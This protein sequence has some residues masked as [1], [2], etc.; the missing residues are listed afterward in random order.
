MEVYCQKHLTELFY[1]KLVLTGGSSFTMKQV[2]L[3]ELLQ[4]QHLKA[5]ISCLDDLGRVDSP[6]NL[7]YI[8]LQKFL[9][10]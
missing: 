2:F 9:I 6:V 8:F 7:N 4:K 3:Q 1:G 5:Y 10:S